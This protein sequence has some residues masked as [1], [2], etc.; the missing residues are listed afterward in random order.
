MTKGQGYWFGRKRF[1]WGISPTSW[2]G[3]ASVVLYCVLMISTTRMGFL[4]VHHVWDLATKVLL[5]VVLL[6]IMFAKFDPSKRT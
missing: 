1:G 5:T 4:T 2:Q 3:W 6:V